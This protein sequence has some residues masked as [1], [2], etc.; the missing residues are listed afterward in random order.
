MNYDLIKSLYN[1][2]KINS[3]NYRLSLIKEIF[4]SD[5]RKENVILLKIFFQRIPRKG[6][7]EYSDR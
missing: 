2:V 7:D 3:G 1:C 5:L 4:D 6:I